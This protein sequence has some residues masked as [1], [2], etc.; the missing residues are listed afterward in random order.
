MIIVYFDASDK[1][2]G[3]RMRKFSSALSGEHGSHNAAATPLSD[4]PSKAFHVAQTQR[5]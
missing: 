1:V 3:D 4:Y 2:I 5:Q